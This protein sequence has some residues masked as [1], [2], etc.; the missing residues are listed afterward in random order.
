MAW[1]QSPYVLVLVGMVA[2]L[3]SGLF[4]IGGGLIMVPI[5][6]LILKMEP[7]QATATSLAVVVLPVALPGVIRL[8]QAG[9]ITWSLVLWVALGFAVASY[10]GAQLNIGLSEVALRRVFAVLL[11]AAAIQMAFKPPKNAP[12]TPAPPETGAAAER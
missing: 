9:N 7:H 12:R 3:S 8:H 5:F 2:G 6:M 10:F 11:I 1:A 4:G